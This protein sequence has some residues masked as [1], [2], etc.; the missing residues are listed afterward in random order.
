MDRRWSWPQVAVVVVVVV[1]GSQVKELV[2]A[3]LLVAQLVET[4]KSKVA[5]EAVLEV[6]V[7]VIP[8]VVLVDL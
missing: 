1:T 7:V 3:E 2:Q 8:Q 5:M 4:D 6:V